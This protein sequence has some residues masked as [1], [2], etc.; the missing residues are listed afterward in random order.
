MNCTLHT[1]HLR[2]LGNV[3]KSMPTL[4]YALQS[5]SNHIPYSLIILKKSE[6]AFDFYKSFIF[7]ITLK[8]RWEIYGRIK[9]DIIGLGSLNFH[10]WKKNQ[11][12]FFTLNR[13]VILHPLICKL[14]RVPTDTFIAVFSGLFVKNTAVCHLNH[15]LHFTEKELKR[16]INPYFISFQELGWCPQSKVS[17][18]FNVALLRISLD[19]WP[20]DPEPPLPG[21]IFTKHWQL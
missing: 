15:A 2:V 8:S 12:E 9:F 5:N 21:H 16:D 10:S 11:W 14:A 18:Y 1:Q 3:I 4:W 19:V 7:L 6:L 17:A 13:I 20:Q